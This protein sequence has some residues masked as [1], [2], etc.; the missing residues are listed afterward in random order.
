MIE[1]NKVPLTTEAYDTIKHQIIDLHLRP[2]EIIMVQQLSRKLGISRT[3]VREALVR[4][5]NEGLVESAEGRK[6]KVCELTLDTII[7]IYDIRE[8][9][10]SLAIGRVSE[11]VTKTQ[12]NHLKNI[13]AKMKVALENKNYDSFFE[14]DSN[15][16]NY[17]IE[18]CGNKILKTLMKQLNDK[19]QRI[20]YLTVNINKRPEDSVVEHTQILECLKNN[21]GEGAKN[22]LQ[23]HLSNVK[24]GL[25]AMFEDTN[26]NFFGKS[27]L[28]R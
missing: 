25:K 21:D 4:L 5:K 15:F 28:I 6:F 12:M 11:I 22:V 2:G 9:L 24:E 16:H 8:C 19:V 23:K 7:E 1:N 10:E 17:I 20:R 14:Q 18:A 3:P 27:F 26:K 13:L